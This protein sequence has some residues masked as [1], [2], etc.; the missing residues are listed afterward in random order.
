M[1]TEKLSDNVIIF[2]FIYQMYFKEL[3]RSSI[4]P[5]IYYISSFPFIP[6]DTS[7]PLVS[8]AFSFKIFL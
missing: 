7:F 5:I 6:F 2:V 4:Y 1:C 3:K 8:F